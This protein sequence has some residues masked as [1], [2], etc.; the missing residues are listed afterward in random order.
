MSRRVIRIP[1]QT[2]Y[3]L[4]PTSRVPAPRHPIPSALL[5]SHHRSC[6]PIFYL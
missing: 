2:N 1:L 6:N 5:P 4:V 3:N